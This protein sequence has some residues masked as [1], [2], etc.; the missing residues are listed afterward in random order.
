MK[1]ITFS[2]IFLLIGVGVFSQQTPPEQKSINENKYA[3]RSSNLAKA[4]AISLATGAGLAIASVV[5][6][7]GEV[8]GYGGCGFVPCTET[9]KNDGIK[10]TLAITGF[11]AIVTSIPLFIMAKKNKKKAASLSFKM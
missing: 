3:K 9:H 2:I 10:S 4:G 6:P 8:E 1:K 5:I 11:L 7:K